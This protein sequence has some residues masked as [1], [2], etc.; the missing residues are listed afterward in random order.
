VQNLR[1][2][3]RSAAARNGAE[4]ARH[5]SLEN[6]E[7]PADFV[8]EQRSPKP[9]SGWDAPPREITAANPEAD[10]ARGI[11]PVVVARPASSDGACV[12]NPAR[13]KA[14]GRNDRGQCHRARVCP[15]CRDTDRTRESTPRSHH[16]IVPGPVARLSLTLTS[17]PATRANPTKINRV[18]RR[19]EKARGSGR[20]E[21]TRPTVGGSK[22]AKG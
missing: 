14:Q 6:A 16:R 11:E 17:Q 4:R 15:A 9:M 22:P 21:M 3:A 12:R 5:R 10:E 19:D 2:G 7:G 13:G 18:G 20:S 1:Q 8:S